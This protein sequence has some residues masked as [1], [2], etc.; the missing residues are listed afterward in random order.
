MMDLYR[1]VRRHWRWFWQR[2]GG[3]G[4]ASDSTAAMEKRDVSDD[5]AEARARF[6]DG[7]REGR[8]EAEARCAKRDQ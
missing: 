2:R 3:I 1:V 4:D 8:R 6:W 7:V 5:R